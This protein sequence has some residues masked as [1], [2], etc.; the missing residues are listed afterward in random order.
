MAYLSRMNQPILRRAL[1]SFALIMGLALARNAQ[2]FE[3]LVVTPTTLQ[4]H[5]LSE[6]ARFAHQRWD[7]IEAATQKLA[8][9]TVGSFE[10]EPT[11]LWSRP[12]RVHYRIY[13]HRYESRGAVVLVPGFTEGLTMYQELIHDLVHNGY[14]VYIHDHRGQG[15]STRLLED[16]EDASKGH[17]DQFDRLVLDLD[18]FAELVQQH[19]ARTGAAAAPLFV[20]AH[21]MGG[22]VVSL[23]LARRGAD[24]PFAAAALI[25][26]M[27]EPTIAGS[28]LSEGVESA[29]RRWC[30]EWSVQLPFQ[31][32][33]LSAR[34]VA[35][36]DFDLARAAFEAKAD[37]A[38]NDLSHSVPRLMRRWADRAATCEGEHC[39]HGDAKI[40]GPTLRWVSQACSG[41]R[42]ARGPEAAQITVPVL[43]LNGGQDTVVQA[44]AQREFC[45]HVNTP[46]AAGQPAR[47]GRC[48]AYT[49]PNARHAVLVEVDTERRPALAHTLAF[50]DCIR[51]GGAGI[52][53]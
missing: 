45:D 31:L 40:E 48:V 44:A 36:Q 18:H 17:M 24:T 12:V 27:H 25:T 29:A 6:E 11:G 39:G 47:T 20:L 7:Q 50:F 49:L 46:S 37:R 15:F 26:P 42:Q 53:R 33:G 23:H 9:L 1:S 51:G 32:P 22:A 2:S 3:T 41:S 43:L 5:A 21:S 19:R 13:Q 4:A 35:G 38:D 28:G 30:D 10:G 8:D 16:T 14:S 34:R 52:C